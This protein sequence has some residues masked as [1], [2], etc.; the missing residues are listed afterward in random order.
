[1]AHSLP[2]NRRHGHWTDS[3]VGERTK[4]VPDRFSLASTVVSLSP[5][6]S[7]PPLPPVPPLR[8]RLSLSPPP[9][10]P[11]Q[12]KEGSYDVV[13]IA[14]PLLFPTPTRPKKVEFD[15]PP[16]RESSLDPPS[17]ASFGLSYDYHSHHSHSPRKGKRHSKQSTRRRRPGSS[18]SVGSTSNEV[19]DSS[20]SHDRNSKR[21]SSGDGLKQALKGIIDHSLE[22]SLLP[23]DFTLFECRDHDGNKDE[24]KDGV[25]E[26]DEEEEFAKLTDNG[27]YVDIFNP[28]STANTALTTERQQSRLDRIISERTSECRNNTIA[29]SPDSSAGSKVAQKLK[30]NVLTAAASYHIRS[31]SASS[32]SITSSTSAQ[33]KSSNRSAVTSTFKA[34]IDK[35][36]V[37][38]LWKVAT[39]R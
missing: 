6:H 19:N 23:A 21:S 26:E 7:P 25:D 37:E 2:P 38:N 14:P 32:S 8:S 16:P 22:S 27:Y 20:P 34:A 13:S 11:L 10:S 30:L 18:Q 28:H 36:K 39:S 17:P 1:M 9:P 4:W 29:I 33:D 12:R 5:S 35:V 3:E 24:Q 15:M 31:L